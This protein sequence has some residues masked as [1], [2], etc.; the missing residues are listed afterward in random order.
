MYRKITKIRFMPSSKETQKERKHMN[1]VPQVIEDISVALCA[2]L[3]YDSIMCRIRVKI[4]SMY[5][6]PFEA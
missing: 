2:R 3:G 1:M 6:M 5:F 4:N